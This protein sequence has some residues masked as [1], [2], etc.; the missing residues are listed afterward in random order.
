VIARGAQVVKQAS[1]ADATT[2]NQD[3]K[4]A[5]FKALPLSLTKSEHL[6]VGLITR[7]LRGG[8]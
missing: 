4:A 3:I 8:L 2:E 1:A 7:I 5:G 6:D